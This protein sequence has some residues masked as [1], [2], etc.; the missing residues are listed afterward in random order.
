MGTIVCQRKETCDRICMRKK[1][2]IF[3][4]V[5]HRCQQVNKKNLRIVA[6]VTDTSLL[7]KSRFIAWE[8]LKLARSH[9]L[10]KCAASLL[11]PGG[12]HNRLR[13]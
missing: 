3:A 9:V 10:R 8:N 7:A 2:E 6:A 5:K 1:W 11:A 4:L 13:E 12:L